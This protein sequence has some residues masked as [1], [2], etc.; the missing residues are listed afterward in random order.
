MTW[1]I[2]RRICGLS[3]LFTCSP[4]A[5][6]ARYTFP[7]AKKSW[8]RQ[9]R[10]CTAGDTQPAR[11]RKTLGELRRG[12]WGGSG[13][14]RERGDI[15]ATQ[16][17]RLLRMAWAD[18]LTGGPT[19][20]EPL[21]RSNQARSRMGNRVVVRRK[22][23]C[24]TSEL[25]LG[26]LSAAQNSLEQKA[27]HRNKKLQAAPDARCGNVGG[28]PMSDDG[29]RGSAKV[30]RTTTYMYVRSGGYAPPFRV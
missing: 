8:H 25:Y 28:R 2:R 1:N 30:L 4:P 6:L 12:C 29:T 10:R 19:G 24:S 5:N 22:C 23:V 21:R 16:S 9:P 17:N 14:V 15:P 27:E 20:T 13:V 7:E 3:P 26:A 18:E 11:R